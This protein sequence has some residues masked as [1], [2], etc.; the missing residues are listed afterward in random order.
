MKVMGNRG[1]VFARGF[2]HVRYS[3]LEQERWIR[4]KTV[5]FCLTYVKKFY[6]IVF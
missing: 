1:F 4:K 2:E 5:P 3:P 6:T